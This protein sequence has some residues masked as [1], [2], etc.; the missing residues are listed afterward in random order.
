MSVPLPGPSVRMNLTVRVGQALRRR[1]RAAEQRGQQQSE[2]DGEQERGAWVPPRLRRL[3]RDNRLCVGSGIAARCHAVA[4]CLAPARIDIGRPPRRMPPQIVQWGVK[5]K[6]NPVRRIVTGHDADG[7]AVVLIDAPTPYVNQ[8]GEGNVTQLLWITNELPVD[9]SHTRDQAARRPA[10]RRPRAARS[11]AS[12]TSR[13]SRAS[14]R[15]ASITTPSSS[16]W[17]SIRRRRAIS[18][19]CTPT[20]RGR[21]TTPSYGRRDRHAA[22]RHRGALQ[23]RRRAGAAGHQPRLGQQVGQAVPHLLRAD[24]LG[25]PPAWKK[26]WKPKK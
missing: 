7:K 4:R 8:R 22:R 25:S 17:A 12:S 23:G 16:R 13:R 5:W 2:Q 15:M 10:C 3:R 19:T 24:R 11:A 26:D 18:A 1:R 14:C 9:L 21:S 20:A 6:R